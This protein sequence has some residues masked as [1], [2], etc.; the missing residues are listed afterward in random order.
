MPGGSA[1]PQVHRAAVLRGLSRKTA[2]QVP[3]HFRIARLPNSIAGMEPLK[4]DVAAPETQADLAGSALGADFIHAPAL[5]RLVWTAGIK[6]NA[7]A[8]FQRRLQPQPHR[9]ALHAPHRA[10]IDPA[11]FSEARVDQR[12]VV[13]AA[14]PAGVK[15]AR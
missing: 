14:Q 5:L 12:L 4:V 9:F 3:V 2:P 6:N 11:L 10:E 1:H 8:G 7:V 15:P 13:G